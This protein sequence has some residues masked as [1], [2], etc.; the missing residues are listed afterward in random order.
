MIGPAEP[1]INRVRN[2][3][4]MDILFKLPKDSKTIQDCK[5]HIQK[6]FA[7][8]QNIREFAG[9]ILIPDVDPV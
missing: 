8:L 4:L 2:Q 6:Q 5:I 3:Y 9:I 1:V 7:I